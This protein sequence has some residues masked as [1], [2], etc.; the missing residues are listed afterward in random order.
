[1][2]EMAAHMKTEIVEGC[3]GTGIKCGVIGEIGC[4][5]PLEGTIKKVQSNLY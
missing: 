5:W 4:S 2:E 1:V 3:E